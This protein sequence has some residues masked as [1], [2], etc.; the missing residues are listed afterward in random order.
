MPGHICTASV[1]LQAMSPLLMEPLLLLQAISA[2]PRTK[3]SGADVDMPD[4]PAEA[5]PQQQS[6]LDAAVA[7]S[8]QTA[9]PSYADTAEL[10]PVSLEQHPAKPIEGLKPSPAQSDKPASKSAGPASPV[11]A[12]SR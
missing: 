10:A 1:Q 11:P 4:L 2:Q 3:I 8:P 6:S 12:P 7:P 9:Q 5:R